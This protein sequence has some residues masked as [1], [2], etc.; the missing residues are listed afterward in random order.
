MK[1][2]TPI[3]R[4]ALLL[5]AIAGGYYLI[6]SSYNTEISEAPTGEAREAAE[7]IP[8]PWLFHQ[9]AYP[10]GRVERT[11]VLE[12][13]RARKQLLREKLQTASQ[14]LDN[15]WEFAG[16]TNIGGR[17]T[18]LE[19]PPSDL[20]TIYVGTASGGIFKTENQGA[21]WTPI[22]DD[23]LSLAIGDIA[24]APSDEN[25]LYVGTGEPNGGAWLGITSVG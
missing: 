19:M 11:A 14:R 1:S 12:A 20:Q 3:L 10:H 6:H 17:V 24:L 18:D 16:A 15:E 9:R 5:L 25:I 13:R 21:D 7:T 8:G 4:V 22:F 2:V 23:A